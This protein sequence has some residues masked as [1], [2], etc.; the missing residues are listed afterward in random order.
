MKEKRYQFKE[1]L[2]K[3]H[4]KDRRDFSAVPK[5]NEFIIND[6]ILL[7][8]PKDASDVIMTAARDFEDYLFVSMNVSSMVTRTATRDEGAIVMRLSDNLGAAQGY[9]GYRITITESG[10]LLEG[11][12]ERGVAQGLYHLEDVMNIRKAPFIETG[13]TERKAVFFRRTSLMPFGMY[14][15]IDEGFAHMAHLG[16][17]TLYLWLEDAYTTNRKDRIDLNLLGKRAKKY[18]IDLLVKLSCPHAKAPGDPGAQEYY[19]KLYGELFEVCPDLAGIVLV[20]ECTEFPSKDPNAES[21]RTPAPEN[22]PRRKPPTGSWPCY[23]YPEW[24][25]LIRNAVRKYSENAEIIFSTYNWGFTPEKNRLE[26]IEN[27]PEGISLEPTWDMFH[28]YR[29]GNAV[30]TVVDYSLSFAGPGE[31]FISEA[32]AAKKRGTR[33]YANAQSSGRTWDFGVVPY[34]P[35]PG[36]WIKRYEAMLKAHED[37]G[38]TGIEENIHYGFQPSII[39]EIEKQMFFTGGKSPAKIL[40]ALVIRDYGADNA[41]SVKRAF[42][43]F[44]EAILHYVPTNEDQ[45]G[46]FRIGPSYPFWLENTFDRGKKPDDTKAMFGNRIYYAEYTTL[47]VNMHHEKGSSL[48]GVRIFE[49][50]ASLERMSALLL[51]GINIL[52]E[53]ENPNRELI[54]LTAL[55]EFM[56]HSVQTVINNKNFFILKQKLNISQTRENA[57]KILDEIEALLLREKKN[58][59]D[60]IPVVNTDSRLGWEPSMEYACDEKAL[61]WKLRQL[62]YTLNFALFHYREHNDFIDKFPLK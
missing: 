33:L 62:D 55:G 40:D 54:K 29:L 3:I 20:G 7:V 60:T 22:L 36:Q 4:K 15:Y 58:V 10:I 35:M 14:E 53:C 57:T 39:S 12:D 37:W 43:C 8:V 52:K 9:M 26:F 21:Y 44:D 17:D 47:D 56:Y 28:Q 48:T 1:E 38:L 24:I 6:G 19:D 11:A 25:E 50:L 31:Y 51:D 41:E 61:N 42:Q 59:E 2:L 46:A 30:E 18:G 32:I 5:S 45:Y 16:M 13:V 23:D 27:L 49:E 34:E